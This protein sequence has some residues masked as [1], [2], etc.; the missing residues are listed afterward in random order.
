M[1][2]LT[3]L[4]MTRYLYSVSLKYLVQHATSRIYRT[5]HI[6]CTNLQDI[7]SFNYIFYVTVCPVISRYISKGILFQILYNTYGVS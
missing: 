1:G 6:S 3:G 2:H 7:M 5:F 4:D